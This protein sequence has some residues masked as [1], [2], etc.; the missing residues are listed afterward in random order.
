MQQFDIQIVYNTREIY[1]IRHGVQLKFYS[2]LCT[3]LQP[4]I[5]ASTVE[6]GHVRWIVMSASG[7]PG[8]TPHDGA[9]SFRRCP[10]SLSGDL[11]TGVSLPGSPYRGLLTETPVWSY[12]TQPVLAQVPRYDADHSG[13]GQGVDGQAEHCCIRRPRAIFSSGMLV[14]L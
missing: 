7:D 3:I 6:S 4:S 1:A 10:L 12:P 13:V 14:F 11:L 9:C 8:G 5:P 2:Q